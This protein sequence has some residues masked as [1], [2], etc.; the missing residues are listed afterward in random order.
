MDDS[1]S[2]EDSEIDVFLIPLEDGHILV[3]P[4]DNHQL[5]VAGGS[6]TWGTWFS[7]SVPLV[8]ALVGDIEG[9]RGH[10][11][12]LFEMS[13]ES[14]EKFREANLD[15]IGTYFRGVLRNEK[16]HA[17]HQV[18]LKEVQIAQQLPT[19]MNLV[20][21]A[22]LATIQAQLN[23]IEHQL[24]EVGENVA[25]VLQFLERNQRSDIEAM[26]EILESVGRHVKAEG[27]ITP[28]HWG[29]I[30]G[31]RKELKALLGQVSGEVEPKIKN[32]EFD[33]TPQGNRDVLK[34]L[35]VNRIVVLVE[36]YQLITSGLAMWIE[37]QL[38]H[39]YQNGEL[40][41]THI[42]EA[43]KD[44]KMLEESGKEFHESLDHA[45]FGS[46]EIIPRT[47]LKM[48]LT[49][50]LVRGKSKDKQA[51][52]EIEEYNEVLERIKPGDVNQRLA[53]P[54][55]EVALEGLSNGGKTVNR[56]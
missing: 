52:Q 27:K 38:L 2:S 56:F 15:Q 1:S 55:I 9:S 5:G 32:L 45:L 10:K 51:L 39:T 50:G 34:K 3:R 44:L 14:L 25:K 40:H 23:R 21:A 36:G 13:P 4:V 53:L 46:P 12:A 20:M 48:L 28:D 7:K 26:F 29:E 31:F 6:S 16:G 33:G 35:D 41:N 30:I 47:K 24:E 54:K 22:Q 17:S 11:G 8:A 19:S 42:E 43:K 49:Q 18:Q 37:F